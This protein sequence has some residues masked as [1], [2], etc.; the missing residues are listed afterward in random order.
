MRGTVCTHPRVQD[1]KSKRQPLAPKD[2]KPTGFNP[3][4]TPSVHFMPGAAPRVKPPLQKCSGHRVRG[5]PAPSS[6]S[7]APFWEAPTAGKAA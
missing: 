7:T 2:V 5:Q 1:T 4:P 3:R 6:T